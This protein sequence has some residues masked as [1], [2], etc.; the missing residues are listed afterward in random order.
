MINYADRAA[1]GVVSPDLRRDFAMSESDYGQVVAIFMA[2]YALM[3]AGSGPIIDRLGVRRGYAVFIVGWSAA[4]MLHSF[5]VGKWSLAACRFMLGF[6]EPGN[7][8]AATKA[9]REWFRPEERA[10]GVGLFNAG[11]S[12]G[13]AIAPPVVT[14]LAFAYG[15][16]NAFTMMG[17]VG[18]VWLAVWWFVYETP[19]DY[20]ETP[21]AKRTPMLEVWRARPSW[22][23]FIARFFTDPVIYFMIFWLP[24][25][26][27]KERGYSASEVG[28]Y[29]WV[30]FLFG[31]IGYTLGG[32]LSG[33][34]MRAG[35]PLPKARKFVLLLGACLMPAALYA[36][37]APTA[38]IAIAMTCF[39][40]FG[41]AF[42]ISNLLTIPADIFH[43]DDVGTAAG[44]TG[45][46]GAIGGMLANLGTGYLVS[47]FSY[48][49]VFILAGLMHPLAVTIV[50]KLLPD[51]YF[52]KEQ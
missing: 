51:R 46:G 23:I 12:I 14:Y 39:V 33:R 26:L 47:S 25:Y 31:D 29:A 21:R 3:Y 35:W 28:H 15:W 19:K 7:W 16:R 52:P 48:T 1:L 43:P 37:F 22:T 24:E 32:W 30:P 10:L 5:A 38:G 2:A 27:R 6:F 49:P 11:S 9:V 36:P 8:P 18:L 34:L 20:V 42:W 4:Q 17:A 13:S 40:T 45:T 50:W 41:H 44:F